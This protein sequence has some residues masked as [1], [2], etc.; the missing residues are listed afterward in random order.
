VSPTSVTY[1]KS[2]RIRFFWGAGG[3]F[4]ETPIQIPK[5][6][7]FSFAATGGWDETWAMLLEERVNWC[8]C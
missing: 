2:H 4:G 8:L 1:V 5:I 6:F 7:S 3:G